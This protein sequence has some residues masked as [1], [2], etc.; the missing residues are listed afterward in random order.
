MATLE[1]YRGIQTLS[2]T[3]SGAGGEALLDNDVALR[4][5]WF[6]LT[7]DTHW[8]DQ[9]PSTSTITLN[10]DLTGWLNVGTPVKFVLSGTTHYALLDTLTSSLMTLVGAPL[11]TGDGDLEELYVGDTDKVE[12]V[13]LHVA[14]NFDDG[15]DAELLVNDEKAPYEWPGPEGRVVHFRAYNDAA[16]TGTKPKVNVRVDGHALCTANSGDGLELDAAQTWYATQVDLDVGNY[17]IAYG[18]DLDLSTTAGSDA[19]DLTVVLAIVR[20]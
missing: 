18:S 13:H 12:I 5:G 17:E 15:A 16:S 8:D 7:E 10:S 20:T 9:P 6:P 1:Y 11:T 2:S 19:S 3:P 4:D 14:G